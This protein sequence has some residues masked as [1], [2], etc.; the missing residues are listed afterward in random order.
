MTIVL[1]SICGFSRLMRVS[2]PTKLLASPPMHLS[3]SQKDSGGISAGKAYNIIG[4]SAKEVVSATAAAVVIK[5]STNAPLYYVT[6]GVA[7][8]VLSKVLKNVIRQP[9]PG[10]V[11]KSDGWGMPSSHAQSLFYFTAIVALNAER[12]VGTGP[13]L[14]AI[15]S[16]AQQVTA[17]LTLYALVASTWRVSSRK[18]SALQTIVGAL[19]GATVGTWT[20]RNEVSVLSPGSAR[21]LLATIN[22]CM[23]CI[24][25]ASIPLQLP[26]WLGG[27]DVASST[28]TAAAGVCTNMA[29]VP[30]N[31]PSRRVKVAL[32]AA[33][34]VVLYHRDLRALVASAKV[35]LGV[36]K[37][38]PIGWSPGAVLG[39]KK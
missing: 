21:G 20:A 11:F 16:A 17:G 36:V 35:R 25:P 31:I 8:A 2:A 28:S 19:V 27:R 32:V 29:S 10:A 5:S 15:G 7:N 14:A 1:P 3:A 18:H 30:R 12:L 38:E 13:G 24:L 26:F 6:A 33:A 34:A 39:Q 37:P 4:T 23:R 9:R 22:K